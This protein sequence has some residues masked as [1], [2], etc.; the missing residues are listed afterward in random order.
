MRSTPPSSCF[1]QLARR[2]QTVVASS[3][4]SLFGRAS[5]DWLGSSEYKF[6]HTVREFFG[7]IPRKNLVG[8]GGTSHFRFRSPTVLIGRLAILAMS[9]ISYAMPHHF[10]I[11]RFNETTLAM[12]L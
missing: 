6:F 8:S 4:I 9:K 11:S 10:F 1:D 12:Q 7:L 3:L 2:K 5:Y